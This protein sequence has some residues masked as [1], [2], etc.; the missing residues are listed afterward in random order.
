MHLYTAIIYS[1]LYEG[2]QMIGIDE[3]VVAKGL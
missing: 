1:V 2:V 3:G